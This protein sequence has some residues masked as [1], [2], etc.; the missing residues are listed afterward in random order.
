MCACVNNK[1][2][3]LPFTFDHFE[4]R[5]GRLYCTRKIIV[6]VNSTR[7]GLEFLISDLHLSVDSVNQLCLHVFQ[8]TV[9]L[10][11][12][13]PI[14]E[15]I[16]FPF[17][18]SG[19]NLTV[20]FRLI[21]TFKLNGVET[22]ATK[23]FFMVYNSPSLNFMATQCFKL[24]QAEVFF[25]HAFLQTGLNEHDLITISSLGFNYIASI[26]KKNYTSR[27]K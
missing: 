5:L 12:E 1:T 9:P 25:P 19:Q 8:S 20:R 22:K 27:F 14:Q 23:G 10:A 21:L 7:T 13:M 6:V 4:I 17:F 16:L 24:R 2:E 15:I 26:V 18:I 3:A 11:P